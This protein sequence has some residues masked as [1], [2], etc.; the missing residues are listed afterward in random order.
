MVGSMSVLKKL[1]VTLLLG[2]LAA[3]LGC[4]GGEEMQKPGENASEDQI[5][6][7]GLIGGISDKA[8]QAV[9]QKSYGDFRSMFTK[10]AEPKSSEIAEFKEY[11]ISI[12]GN[13]AEVISVSGSE[14]TVPVSIMK[15]GTDN[16]QSATWKATKG[17]DGKWL[18]SDA[19]LP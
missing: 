9:A 4:S 11:A 14:A 16:A 17:D 3:Q 7:S 5:A 1:S 6:I 13:Y 18:L 12:D 10:D 19:K 15:Y 2:L 8:S